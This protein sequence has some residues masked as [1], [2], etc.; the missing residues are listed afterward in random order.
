[1]TTRTAPEAAPRSEAGR[2]GP[3]LAI[4]LL[5][6]FMAILDVAVVNV[7]IPAIRS[8]LHT[9]YGGVEFVISAYTLTHAALLVTGGRLGDVYGRKRLFIT[10]LLV[11]SAASALCGAAP[12]SRS[13]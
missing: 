3:V 8:D 1:M 13:W 6:T 11:F 9:S 2:T 12:G 7:A 5:G 10:G 4:V